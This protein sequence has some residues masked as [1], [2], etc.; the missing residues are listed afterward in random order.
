MLVGGA[1]CKPAERNYSPIEGEA[2]AIFKGKQDT[3]YYTQGC[4]KLHIATDH[5]PLTTIGKQSVA[6]VPNRRLARIK[7]KTMR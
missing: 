5:Q 6:D 1:F 7:E 2:T 3:N 4:K